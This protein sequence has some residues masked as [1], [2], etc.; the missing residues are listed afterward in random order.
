MLRYLAIINAARAFGLTQDEIEAV[1]G[2][3]DARRLRCDQL[4][5]A[6]GDLI[7]GRSLR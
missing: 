5:E 3:F 7:V 4:A 6:F 1:A 2:P